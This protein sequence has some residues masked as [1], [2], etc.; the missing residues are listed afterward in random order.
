VFQYNQ[1]HAM[2]YVPGNVYVH[3]EKE[4]EMQEE[5][6]KRGNVVVVILMSG[7]IVMCVI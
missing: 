3:K 7:D 6:E 2:R 1:H 5:E 4:R